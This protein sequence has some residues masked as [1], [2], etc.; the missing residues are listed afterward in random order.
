[1]DMKAKSSVYKNPKSTKSKKAKMSSRKVKTVFFDQK[2]II[3]HEY[4]PPGQTLTQDYSI[5][6][7]KRLRDAICRKKDNSCMTVGSYGFNTIA[8][9]FIS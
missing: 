9:L 7:L 3:H 8:L 1:M 4:A 2:G 6:S 5:S